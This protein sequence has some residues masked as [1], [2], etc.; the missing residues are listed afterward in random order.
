MHNIKEEV[1]GGVD[2]FYGK[3]VFPN[4]RIQQQ[5]AQLDSS[6]YR[7]ALQIM[8]GCDLLNDGFAELSFNNIHKLG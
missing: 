3:N 4:E 7:T 5:F 2:S 8:Q 6:M 1:G